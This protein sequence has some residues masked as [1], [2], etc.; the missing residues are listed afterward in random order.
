MIINLKGT[1]ISDYELSLQESILP[2]AQL[3][4]ESMFGTA[5]A[6]PLTVRGGK[7]AGYK[8][9]GELEAYQAYI[10]QLR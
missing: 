4:P 10:F 8:P 9:L 6:A 2:D 5:Q 1:P 3:T 7:F